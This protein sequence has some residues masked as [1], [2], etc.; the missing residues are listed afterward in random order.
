M[1]DVVERWLIGWNNLV[2]ANKAGQMLPIELITHLAILN[3]EL[4]D[5][6]D[7]QFQ[8]SEIAPDSDMLD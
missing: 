4:Q 3:Q 8:I 7:L 6:V 5:N 1:G 2:N